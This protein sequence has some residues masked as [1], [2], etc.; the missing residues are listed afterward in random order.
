MQL[1]QL[2]ERFSIFFLSHPVP[3]VQ[4]WFYPHL[5]VWSTHRSLVLRLPWSSWVCPCEDR[6][7]R[8]YDCLDRGSLGSAKCAGKRRPRGTRDMAL[9]RAFSGV[10]HKAHEGQPWLGFFWCLAAGARGPT[11]KGLFFF[12]A[13]IRATSE[14]AFFY[15]SAA[16]TREPALSGLLLLS[17]AGAGTWGERDYNS[18]SCPCV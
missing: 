2:M 9:V 11:L 12:I 13:H 16:G 14:G 4:L 1:V 10:R 3:G 7:Q 17:S 6:A 5:C 15:C 8:W 18:G